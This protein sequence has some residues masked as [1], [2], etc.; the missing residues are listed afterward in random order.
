MELDFGGWAYQLHVRGMMDY[1][2]NKFPPLE[3]AEECNS[4][5][6]KAYKILM[7]SVFEQLAKSCILKNFISGKKGVE[8]EFYFSDLPD[9]QTDTKSTPTITEPSHLD[10]YSLLKKINEQARE[11]LNSDHDEHQYYTPLDPEIDFSEVYN[12]INETYSI[13][14]FRYLKVNLNGTNQQIIDDFSKWLKV[15][16]S[17]KRKTI[18]KRFSES[19]LAKWHRYRVLSYIDLSI[20]ARLNNKNITNALFFNAL[21]PHEEGITPDTRIGKT[22]K[23][24]YADKLILHE[25]ITA[26]LLQA[27]GG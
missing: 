19:D 22:V 17:K 6:F 14:P 8:T 2:L 26:L 24:K 23:R 25:T 10:I 20:W 21:F 27:A 5:D 3:D 13:G 15:Q 7:D 4:A 18:N 16:K 11:K 12:S 9:K 1:W